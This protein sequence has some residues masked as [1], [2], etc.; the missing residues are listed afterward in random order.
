ME[1][2][3]EL[4]RQNL[5]TQ[6]LELRMLEP[7]LENAEQVWNAIK[8]E[9]RE[10]FKYVDWTPDNIKP[11]QENYGLP[12]SFSETITQM[13]QEQ[14]YDVVQGDGAVWY[15]FHNGQLIGHHGVFYSSRWNCMEGGDVW[16]IKSAW[17]Q[18]FN[19]EIW[20]LIIQKAFGELGVDRINRRCFADNQRSK[21]SIISSGFLVDSH[22][23]CS[24][25]YV[26]GTYKK[27]LEFSLYRGR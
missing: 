4:F 15:V 19:R 9:N 7:T 14:E 25:R 24:S 11:L 3:K 5:M 21:K 1:R 18:G 27:V 8:T 22:T 6:R 23:P 16:F 26:C 12:Q 10:D 20:S 17:G 2:F 13:R